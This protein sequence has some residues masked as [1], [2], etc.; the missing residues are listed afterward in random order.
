M[1]I[2]GRGHTPTPTRG[3][4]RPQH[5]KGFGRGDATRHGDKGPHQAPRKKISHFNTPAK[6]NSLAEFVKIAL[7]SRMLRTGRRHL[8]WGDRTH[9]A[10]SRKNLAFQPPLS[11][12]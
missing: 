3:E 2:H 5:I 7:T 1:I 12:E 4:I 11:T 8:A 10:T 9:W 6:K